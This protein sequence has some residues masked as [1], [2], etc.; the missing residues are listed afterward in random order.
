MTLATLVQQDQ[1]VESI[2]LSF[3]ES[4]KGLNKARQEEAAQALAESLTQPLTKNAG[5]LAKLYRQHPDRQVRNLAQYFAFAIRSA[6]DHVICRADHCTEQI[7]AGHTDLNLGLAHID[8]HLEL[9]ESNG[10]LYRQ[11]ITFAMEDSRHAIMDTRRLAVHAL[12]LA[13]ALFHPISRKV[14]EAAAKNPGWMTTARKLDD[15]REHLIN[16]LSASEQ[17]YDHI[18]E[19]LEL[20]DQVNQTCP[21]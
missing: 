11:Y 4:T 21:S 15:A 17:G 6:A 14:A 20:I 5:L 18:D 1:D 3:Q 19:A 16:S 12:A 13:D 7:A 8:E 9:A 10:H 2:Y